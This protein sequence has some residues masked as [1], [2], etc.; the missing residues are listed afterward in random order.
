MPALFAPEPK[1]MRALRDRVDELEEEVR[2][3]REQLVPPLEFPSA[4]RLTQSEASVLAFL[5]ARNPHAMSRE[6]VLSAVWGHCEDCPSEKIIDVV[7]GKMRMKL[8]HTG[9]VI[10]TRWGGGFALSRE[11]CSLLAELLG[12]RRTVRRQLL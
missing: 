8:K 1:R 2:Q 10:D 4:W 5:Y 3:L 11:S 7:I 12:D 9:I 6:R